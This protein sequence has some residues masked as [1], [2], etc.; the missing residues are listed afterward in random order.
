MKKIFYLAFSLVEIVVALI[1]FSVITAAL[2]PIITK[3]LK[4]T[5]ITIGGGDGGTL[6]MTCDEFG[7]ECGLCYPDR[8]VSCVKSCLDTQALDIANCKCKDC[9]DTIDMFG[10]NCLKC[11]ISNCSKCIATNYV[12]SGQCT[13]CP[14][15]YYCDGTS[16]TV[17]PNGK[18]TDTTGQTSCKDCEAGYYCK[19]GEKKECA[20]GKYSSANSSDCSV[21]PV[22]YYCPGVSDKILCSTNHK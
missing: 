2:A 15:K 3:K 11:D 20:S 7:P 4:S 21:C 18:Y 17:C 13:I 5:G 12:D 6:Q 19:N 9:N 1:I 8:C 16:K 14:I 22:G 10:P